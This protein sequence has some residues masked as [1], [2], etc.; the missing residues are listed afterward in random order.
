MAKRKIIVA[1]VA[2]GI[3]SGVMVF[4][5]PASAMA[6][7]WTWYNGQARANAWQDTKSVL[8]YNGESVSLNGNGLTVALKDVSI[9]TTTGAGYVSWSF[10][11]RKING[12][13]IWYAPGSA[14]QY[15]PLT[16]NAY[17]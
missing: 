4:G 15:G 6:A 12:G 7:T 13:C 2:I 16:C 14:A 11:S 10:S 8:T 9:G 1:V 5:M 3:A 17:Y